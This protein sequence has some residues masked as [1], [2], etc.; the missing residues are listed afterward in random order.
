DVLSLFLL[1]SSMVSLVGGVVGCILGVIVA[2]VISFGAG[3]ALGIE[4]VAAVKPV[5]LLGGIAVAMVVGVLSG[6]YPARKASRMSP[7]EAVRYE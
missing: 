4:F 1:E 7:V 6:F 3:S 5:V 2:R